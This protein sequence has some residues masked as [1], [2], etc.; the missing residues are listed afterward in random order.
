MG[1]RTL[2]RMCSAAPG[3]SVTYSH[4]VAMAF[5][6][7]TAGRPAVSSRSSAWLN[8]VGVLL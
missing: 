1:A 8:A 5:G 6:K 4:I 2:S 7:V 3:R